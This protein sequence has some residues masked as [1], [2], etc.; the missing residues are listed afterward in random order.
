MARRAKKAEPGRDLA[1]AA[2]RIAHDDNAEDITI[3]DLR[4]IS[5]V[6]DYFVIC[7]GTS[8]RQL[9]TVAD[10]IAQYGK[11]IGQKVW[12]VA[13]AESATWIVLDFV[14]VVVH[15][16]DPKHREY[17]DLELIWGESPRVE[18]QDEHPP[19]KPKQETKQG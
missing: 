13:G 18:W 1:V 8:N 9:R 15:L 16:F 10:D 12:H 7:T 2:A 17:Y 11:E 3:L 5:P 19:K 14:D 6:T 4:D